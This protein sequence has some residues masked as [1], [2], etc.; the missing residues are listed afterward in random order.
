M[1]LETEN[2]IKGT[3][4]QFLSNSEEVINFGMVSKKKQSEIKDAAAEL[5]LVYHFEKPNPKWTPPHGVGALVMKRTR[6]LEPARY[7]S[8]LEKWECM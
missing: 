6:S 7:D 2:T 5:D 8:A 1:K 4:I 3:I